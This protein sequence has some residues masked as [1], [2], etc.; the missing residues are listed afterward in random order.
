M[1]K[2]HNNTAVIA[3]FE[4]LIFFKLLQILNKF[5]LNQH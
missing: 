4:D 1:P 2:F 3:T 5:V